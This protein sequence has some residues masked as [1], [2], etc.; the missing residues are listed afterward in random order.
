MLACFLMSFLLPAQPRPVAPP[1][2][3]VE[4]RNVRATMGL[5]GPA[6]KDQ[7]RF[8]PG[9]L[10]LYSFDLVNLQST[11][12]GLCRYAL[13]VEFLDSKGAILFPKEDMRLRE[14]QA[15]CPLAGNQVPTFAFADTDPDLK[16][17]RYMFRV[18]VTDRLSGRT[19]TLEKSFEIVPRSFSLIRL[20]WMYSTSGETA[21]PLG[22][23]GQGFL[24]TF[25]VSQFSVEDKT[26]R[27]DVEVTIKVLDESGK[28]VAM[29]P[30]TGQIS[31]PEDEARRFHLIR[32]PFQPNR[33]GQFVLEITATDRK[34][35][36]SPVTSARVPFS[37]VE[38]R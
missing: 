12:E 3:A 4:F 6:R 22:T 28:P 19:G 18:K 21:P 20:S 10:I 36:G 14:S 33:P 38:P 5:L 24:L 34:A 23:P 26:G 2:G 8:Q 30:F 31:V 9:E 16:P 7:D 29:K 25:V 15:L 35:A 32:F 1:T 11:P 13:G 27:S 37:V 17:G